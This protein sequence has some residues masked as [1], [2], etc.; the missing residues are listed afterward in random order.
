LDGKAVRHR[1]RLGQ[2][3]TDAPLKDFEYLIHH[4]AVDNKGV[5]ELH[6]CFLYDHL[7]NLF[8]QAHI[9]IY[10][11]KVTL[12]GQLIDEGTFHVIYRLEPTQEVSWSDEEAQEKEITP[13]RMRAGMT[14]RQKAKEW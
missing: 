8:E 14:L 10:N 11:G 2:T 12:N 3:D 4:V 6:H 7:G 5:E 1:R 13:K 9:V